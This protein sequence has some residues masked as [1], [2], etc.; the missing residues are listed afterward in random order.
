M[1]R[2]I[3]ILEHVFALKVKILDFKNLIEKSVGVI[4]KYIVI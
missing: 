1:I 4:L 2:F 3:T